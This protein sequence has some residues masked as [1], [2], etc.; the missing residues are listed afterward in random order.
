MPKIGNA[1]K[2]APHSA[3]AYLCGLYSPGHVERETKIQN[4]TYNRCDLGR[5]HQDQ[6]RRFSEVFLVC[7]KIAIKACNVLRCTPLSCIP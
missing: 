6:Q 4:A 3:N 2:S 1:K 5:I 7:F